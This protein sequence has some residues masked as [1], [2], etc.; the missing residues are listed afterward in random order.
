M[1][2]VNMTD[3]LLFNRIALSARDHNKTSD[4]VGKEVC[5]HTETS[6]KALLVKTGTSGAGGT[7]GSNGAFLTADMLTFQSREST[8]VTNNINN[9]SILS[10]CPS[11]PRQSTSLWHFLFIIDKIYKTVGLLCLYTLH[12]L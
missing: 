4:I 10:R 2:T 1:I 9:G 12:L 3:S 8:G 11:K 6:I 7:P 5:K